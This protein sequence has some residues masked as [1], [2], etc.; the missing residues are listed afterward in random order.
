MRVRVQ[1]SPA[2][3][4]GG[5]PSAHESDGKLVLPLELAR[6]QRGG[7]RPPSDGPPTTDTSAG[8]SAAAAAVQVR[9]RVRCGRGC[10][11]SGVSHPSSAAAVRSSRKVNTPP[12][13]WVP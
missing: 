1:V 10:G 13:G 2:G 8:A 12:V 7:I 4:R 6:P 3:L 9:V 5:R 11:A